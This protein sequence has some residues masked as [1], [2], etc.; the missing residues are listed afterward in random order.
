MLLQSDRHR[1]QELCEGQSRWPSLIVLMVS[2]D[3]KQHLKKKKKKKTKKKKTK[4]KKTKNRRKRR[5]RGKKK[6]KKKKT[7]KK[8][9]KK[10]KTKNRRKRRRRGKKKKKKKEKD[11]LSAKATVLIRLKC[12]VDHAVQVCDSVLQT[13]TD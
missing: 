4:K 2:V 3:V 9:T 13:L 11:G 7:K 8:K 5:R 6:K 12:S 1:A 10:K